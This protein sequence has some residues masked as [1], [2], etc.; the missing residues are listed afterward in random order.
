MQ[1]VIFKLTGLTFMK[2]GL[3]VLKCD[4]KVR[5]ETVKWRYVQTVFRKK[6]LSNHHSKILRCIQGQK[7]FERSYFGF[8]KI[9]ETNTV[10]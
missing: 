10:L 2:C 8:F 3:R 6:F 1:W 4:Y 7:W 5:E 9:L